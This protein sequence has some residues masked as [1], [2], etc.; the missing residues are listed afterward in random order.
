MSELRRRWSRI[1]RP[2]P[3]LG[4]HQKTGHEP[5]RRRLVCCVWGGRSG[6]TKACI[7]WTVEGIKRAPFLKTFAGTVQADRTCPQ[8]RRRAFYQTYLNF[9]TVISN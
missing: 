9:V 4:S 7:Q 3:P 8:R 1:V 6:Q 5:G 2:S